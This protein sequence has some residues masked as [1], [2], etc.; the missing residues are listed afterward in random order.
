MSECRLP[1]RFSQHMSISTD[2][3]Y[4]DSVLSN[5]WICHSGK[6]ERNKEQG[7]EKTEIENTINPLNEPLTRSSGS[8]VT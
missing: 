1:W 4:R 5:L 8:I 3:A 6:N 7:K 2:S